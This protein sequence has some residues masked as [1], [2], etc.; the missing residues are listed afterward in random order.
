MYN[1]LYL[2]SYFVLKTMK[3]PTSFKSLGDRHQGVCTSRAC[4]H[5]LVNYYKLVI[6]NVRNKQRNN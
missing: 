3:T 4:V 5:L 1:F 2:Y 6:T